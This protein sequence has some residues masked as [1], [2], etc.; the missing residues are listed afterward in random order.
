MTPEANKRLLDIFER[1]NNNVQEAEALRAQHVAAN[2]GIIMPSF[3]QELGELSAKHLKAAQE[4]AA[5][6][7]KAAAPAAAP[8]KQPSTFKTKSGISWSY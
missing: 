1:A 5:A 2:N 8:A 6:R 4:E 3:R 7:T